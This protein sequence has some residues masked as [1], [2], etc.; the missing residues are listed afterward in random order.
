MF[1]KE[2]HGIRLCD[3]FLYIDAFSTVN[4]QIDG[5]PFRKNCIFQTIFVL[6]FQIGFFP[7]EEIYRL[8]A[9]FFDIPP[10][11]TSYGFLSFVMAAKADFIRSYIPDF[12]SSRLLRV[13]RPPIR[14]VSFAVR[15]FQPCS[16]TLSR[17][18]SSFAISYF[19]S[20]SGARLFKSIFSFS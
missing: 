2:R 12:F 6:L 1:C 3:H 10:P 15:A 5:I 9:S 16:I 19:N 17:S 18:P 11:Q 13:I 7:I 8:K 14:P 4:A 20:S